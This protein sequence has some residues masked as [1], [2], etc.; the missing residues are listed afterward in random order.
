MT[1]NPDA[2][3][4]SSN[5][6]AQA[7]QFQNLEGAFR[8]LI[9]EI[10]DALVKEGYQ[11]PTPIQ[12]QCIQQLLKGRDVLGCAQT[13][14]GKT[15]AFT[16]PLLQRLNKDSRRPAKGTPRA[17]ILA[18]TRELAAQIGDSIKAYSRFLNITH[19]VIFGGVSQHR[20]VQAMRRGVDIVVATPGRLIDLMD[21]KIV[22]LDKVETFI[23]DE[24]DRMLDMG[25]IP[26]I[27]TIVGKL[28]KKRQTLFFSATMAPEML[29][30]AEPMLKAPVSVTIEPD[31]PAV[32]RISQ[33]VLFV[34][35]NNKDELL[36]SLL[37]DRSVKKVIVFTQMKHVANRVTK[38]LMN[39]GI[40][41]AAIHGN[42]SQSARTKALD[43]FKGNRIR[44][45]VA[46]DVAARGIDVDDITH[47]INYDLPVEAET[48]VHRIGRTA[49]AGRDGDAI[50]F[51]TS[52]D[53]PYL[54]AIQKLLGKPVPA[55]HDHPFHCEL[56]ARP[57][58]D[59]AKPKRKSN[60]RRGG[61]K[62]NN[63]F[64]RNRRRSRR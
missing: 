37:G 62:S 58:P 33:R 19:T 45:L 48:Y 35:R 64:G 22:R 63:R 49:R 24:V 26:A 1:K 52:D 21:Q 41:S 57:Q 55:D 20:Q 12:E 61:G 46:T 18:P 5:L 59:G 4:A 3:D 9:P 42:K 44:V 53:Q 51:C 30:L 54:G 56:S 39:S 10:A 13:G 34:R 32:E 23:L 28:P 36:V 14:T 31:K 27:R 2:S 16:L 47:V 7:S 17:L 6:P 29:R 60:G 25:F 50:S 40:E 43:G 8:L 38:Q 15:A 11:K